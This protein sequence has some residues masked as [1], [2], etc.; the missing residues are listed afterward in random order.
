MRVLP[1]A[2][3]RHKERS[4]RRPRSSGADYLRLVTTTPDDRAHATPPDP[5]NPRV[6]MRGIEILSD[7]WYTLR[8]ATF[9]YQEQ[10]GSWSTH[11][12]EAYGRGSGATILRPAPEAA[13]VLLTRQF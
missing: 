13:T 2:H 12:R 6:R 10:D 4:F 3:Q 9:E 8:K 1:E 5:G 7:N 11:S